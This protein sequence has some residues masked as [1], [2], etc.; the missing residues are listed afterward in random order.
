MERGGGKGREE[1]ERRGRERRTSRVP[2]RRKG[3][4]EHHER[5]GDVRE[6]CKEE[7]TFVSKENGRG[8]ARKD[9]QGSEPVL[10]PLTHS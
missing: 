9:A 2:S 7:E 4:A 1:E 8:K 5:V 6:I 3:D 10:T